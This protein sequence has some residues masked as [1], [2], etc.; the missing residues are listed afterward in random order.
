MIRSRMALRRDREATTMAQPAALAYLPPTGNP[1]LDAYTARMGQAPLLGYLVLYSIFDGRVKHSDLQQWVR[2]LGLDPKMIPTP[3]RPLNA[4][5]R[6]TGTGVNGVRKTY[7]L[8]EP[9]ADPADRDQQRSRGQATLMIREVFHDRTRIVK[10]I[11]REEA[12]ER[13]GLDY[14]PHLAEVTFVRDRSSRAD[15][16]AGT[17]EVLPDELAIAQLPPPEQD[18]VREMLAEIHTTYRELC[19]F[20]PGDKLRS[21]VHDAIEDL[22]ATRVRPTGGV[23]FVPRRH[24]D[25]VAALR[26]LISRFGSGSELWPVPLPDEAEMRD[27]V[28][29]AF[30]NKAK[31]DLHKLSLDIANARR[32]GEVSAAA[33]EAMFKRYRQLQA[34][35]NEH[36]TLLST[37]LH[38]THSALKLVNEQL[39]SLLGAG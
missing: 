1:Q 17:L 23:Y 8:G 39:S 5:K 30:R 37:D 34:V 36:S 29:S 35:T 14:N 31:E 19:L 16:G 20:L 7:T 3:V 12:S 9:N 13:T 26:E 32:S 24:A 21:M 2:E 38:E 27:M 18:H 25:T 15:P 33:I 10:R 11:V 6:V 28:V 4:F 22:G